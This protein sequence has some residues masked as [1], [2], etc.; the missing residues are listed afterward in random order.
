[1]NKYF[2][3]FAFFLF[4]LPAGSFGAGVNLYALDTVTTENDSPWIPKQCLLQYAG[5]IGLFSVGV[6][7][8]LFNNKIFIRMLYG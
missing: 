5:D 6:E 8:T 7:N 1:M 4:V 3:N 2:R